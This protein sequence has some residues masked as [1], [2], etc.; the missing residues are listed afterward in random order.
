M[1]VVRMAGHYLLG[2]ILRARL[3]VLGDW[4]EILVNKAPVYASGVAAAITFIVLWGRY[5]GSASQ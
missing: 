1:F 2:V 3:A 5:R 4:A